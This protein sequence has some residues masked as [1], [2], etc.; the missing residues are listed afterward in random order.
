M[1][2]FSLDR[3]AL[4]QLSTL[5]DLIYE[6]ATDLRVWQQVPEAISRWMGAPMCTLFTPA[7]TPLD[8]GF[9]M[10]HNLSPLAMEM[11]ATKYQLLD[12]W[13]LRAQE[14]GLAIT[15][16]AFR[17]QDLATEE[18]FL[19]TEMYR[20]FFAPMNVGRLASGVVFG[21]DSSTQIPVVCS[22]NRP[23]RQPFLADDLFKLQ[24]LLPHLSRALGVMFRLR[25][26]D[27]KLA[28][29][30]A[31]LDKLKQAVVL[32]SRDG[33]VYHANGAAHE[34]FKQGDG[35]SLTTLGRPTALARLRAADRV[36]QAR[37]D[38]SLSAALHAD[39]LEAEHFS[40]ALTISRP[41][42]LPAYALHFSSLPFR[43]DFGHGAQAPAAI[44]FVDTGTTV[45]KV[46]PDVLQQRYD[47]RDAELRVAQ[48]ATEGLS[49]ENLAEEL[50]ISTNTVKTH[51][52]RIYVKT[53]AKSRS[54]LVKL[55]MASQALA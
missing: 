19:A 43:N 14:R 4:T 38:T 55:V 2:D 52:K 35:L 20:D 44:A 16:Y 11:W 9:M 3:H 53:G 27:F 41:S 37:L 22:C 25:E 21:L 33:S 23:L 30:L 40:L 47:L 46:N 48:L 8:G 1:S 10:A 12:L 15:G 50:G 24:L 29:T 36:Q 6:G 13:A 7:H 28:S 42:G 49:V 5:I 45:V 26:A 18:E 51:L 32:F 54:Q 34:L 31:A 39:P 17:D